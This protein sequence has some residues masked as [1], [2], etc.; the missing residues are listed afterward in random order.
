MHPMQN[1]D[2][3]N[4]WWSLKMKALLSKEWLAYSEENSEKVIT[5]CSPVEYCTIH[6]MKENWWIQSI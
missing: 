4:A 2:K 1:K 3:K 6:C 5:T